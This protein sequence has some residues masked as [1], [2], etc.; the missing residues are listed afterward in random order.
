MILDQHIGE[1]AARQG[2]VAALAGLRVLYEDA[3]VRRVQ[4]VEF[5]LVIHQRRRADLVA[6]DQRTRRGR[7]IYFCPGRACPHPAGEQGGE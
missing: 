4:D 3:V 1:I 5:A 7:G 2:Q 6:L